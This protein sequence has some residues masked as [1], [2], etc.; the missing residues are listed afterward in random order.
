MRQGTS[1]SPAARCSYYLSS[2]EKTVWRA[3][4]TSALA[5]NAIMPLSDLREGDNWSSCS[6]GSSFVGVEGVPLFQESLPLVAIDVTERIAIQRVKRARMHT[7]QNSH[8]ARNQETGVSRG[9]VVIPMNGLPL[10][11]LSR[12]IEGGWIA[13]AMGS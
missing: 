11:L 10:P 2:L 7:V 6:S 5:A 12:R 9:N 8:T 13:R 4:K 3:G 1:R